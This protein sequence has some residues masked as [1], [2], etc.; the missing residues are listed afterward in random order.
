MKTSSLNRVHQELHAAW[1]RGEPIELQRIG[2]RRFAIGENAA[3]AGEFVFNAGFTDG[4][5]ATETE[6]ATNRRGRHR[7]SGSQAEGRPAESKRR[8]KG[9]TVA[10]V[11]VLALAV[12][13]WKGYRFASVLHSVAKPHTVTKAQILAQLPKPQQNTFKAALK[14]CLSFVPTVPL[15]KSFKTFAVTRDITIGGE[16]QQDILIDCGIEQRSITVRY[17]YSQGYWHVKSATPTGS[18]S[19]LSSN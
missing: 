11:V 15:E 3:T 6:A 19:L 12:V 1:Q 5:A 2:D 18:R 16:R 9:G 10:I 17:S 7:A 14:E 8:M 13:A 4:P